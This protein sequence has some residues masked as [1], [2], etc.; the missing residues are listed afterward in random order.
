[1]ELYKKIVEETKP[2]FATS[3]IQITA[4]EP[5][6]IQ[7]AMDG[8]F[9]GKDMEVGGEKVRAFRN[10]KEAY[11]VI[12]GIDYLDVRV[13]DLLRE[14][15]GYD[16]GKFNV[17]LTETITSA[18]WPYILGTSITRK[19]IAAFRAPALDEWRQVAS[20]IANIPDYKTQ[21]RI[22][23]GHYGPLPTR[24]ADGTYP[25]VA[26]A[27][28]EERVTYNVNA[29]GVIESITEKVVVNDD[30][31]AIRQIPDRLAYGAKLRIFKEVFDI[32]KDSTQ[33]TTARGNL[34]S[35]ALDSSSLTAAKI[36]MRSKTLPGSTEAFIGIKPRFLV[37]PKNLEETAWLLRNSPYF[38]SATTGAT[39]MIPNPHQNTFDI[40]VVDYWTDTNDWFLVAD[41][42]TCPTLEVG[43]LEGRQEP[44]L[45]TEAPGT[46][47]AFT[48]GKLSYRAR[49]DVGAVMLQWRSFDGNIVA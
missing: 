28:P 11:A 35:A 45:A 15:W 8:F 47:S 42:A 3:Q 23:Q 43:F 20:V 29:Y 22:Y 21:E 48:A 9:F 30:L 46:G 41:P 13:D 18:D 17:R 19:M 1:M 26:T 36:R 10:L 44:E 12:K 16:S 33:Y 14:A 32:V 38:V 5:E 40:I 6:K 39:P 27:L 24:D 7:A 4:T 37:I 31:G 25:S 49:I 2:K 34:G